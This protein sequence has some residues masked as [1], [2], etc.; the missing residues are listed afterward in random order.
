MSGVGFLLDPTAENIGAQ[1]DINDGSTY[2]VTAFEF[3]TPP[4]S[5][6]Y[7][8]SV[9]T[10]G[11][12]LYASR[13]QNRT[14]TLKVL[15]RSASDAGLTS[16]VQA[17]E[18]KVGKINRDAVVSRTGVGGVLQYTTPDG[19]IRKFDVCTATADA[20]WDK[21][22]AAR[23]I[24]NVTVTL[25]CL[26]LWRGAETALSDHSETTLPLLTFTET[27][28]GDVPAAIRLV[29][30]EDQGADQSWAL[31]ALR[32]RNRTS[33][34]TDKL[35]Y[36]AESLTL[37]GAGAATSTSL[38]GYSG[39]SSVKAPNLTQNEAGESIILTQ[40][41]TSALT[42]VTGNA[43]TDVFTKTAHGLTADTRVRLSSLSGG[44]G[45]STSTDYYVIS[46]TTDTFQLALTIGGSAVD[47]GS[48][49]TSATVTPQTHLTHTGSYRVF[50]RAA[51]GASN[52]G[53]V[54][55]ALQ[56]GAGDFRAPTT[57]DYTYLTSTRASD[58]TP[59]EGEWLLLDLGLVRLPADSAQWQGQ[60]LAWS[61]IANDDVYVD[62]VMLVPV[63]EGYGQVSTGTVVASTASFIARSE[64]TTESGSPVGDSLAS[65]GTWSAPAS[66]YETD[67]FAVSGGAMTRSSASADTSTDVR[68]GRWIYASGTTS[69]TDQAVKI[70]TQLPSTGHRGGVI[71]RAVDKDN[72]MCAHIQASP[73]PTGRPSSVLVYKVVAGVQTLKAFLYVGALGYAPTGGG[74]QLVVYASGIWQAYYRAFFTGTDYTLFGQ[75][76]DADLATGGALASGGAGVFDWATSNQSTARTYNAFYVWAPASDAACF[77]SR[78]IQFASDG[79]LRQDTA[80]KY[81]TPVSVYRGD[82]L[83]MPAGGQEAR[84]TEF[85]VKMCRSNPY[86][87]TDGYI[88]NLS[89]KVYATP[90]GLVV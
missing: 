7:A 42:S 12:S 2:R 33:A 22:F 51:A 6:Q 48:T 82:M 11:E 37:Q 17:L 62:Y 88:D 78:S 23:R 73:G 65:G 64:F 58:G 15:V 61:S 14:V 9:D 43:S 46:P 72:F 60:I 25:T 63:D 13:Y 29:V 68:Y 39:S 57:N 49:L 50:V 59:V 67:D 40:M 55:M 34:L 5:A 31:V 56:W 16:A 35:F 28:G 38:S 32:S 21:V 47:I 24:V 71:A 74:V 81:L 53:T 18:Q 36:Q 27:I 52:A 76:Y 87:G 80:G 66:A 54:G 89:A 45:L 10:H 75:G 8:S 4:I 69:M 30:D 1:L 90:R 20:E 79:V 3:P 86:T 70:I 41:T 19:T 26:P 44:S 83:T 77:A 84:S 85:L